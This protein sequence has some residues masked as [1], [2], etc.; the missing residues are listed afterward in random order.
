LRS[1]VEELLGARL[2][3]SGEPRDHRSGMVC[4]LVGAQNSKSRRRLQGKAENRRSRFSELPFQVSPLEGRGCAAI[5]N[6]CHQD[7][8]EFSL[9]RSRVA[10]WY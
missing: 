7:T 1:S 9:T 3:L 4:V 5:M 2:T 10:K 6:G 8:Y